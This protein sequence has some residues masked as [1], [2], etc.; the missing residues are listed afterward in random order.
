MA[1]ARENVVIKIDVDAKGIRPQ[2]KLVEERLKAF[3]RSVERNERSLK[4]LSTE[5]D[6][7]QRK[8]GVFNRTLATTNKHV[9]TTNKHVAKSTSSINKASTAM[10]RASSNA[11]KLNRRVGGLG[12]TFRKVGMFAQK[13][14]KVLTKFSFIVYAVEV[15]VLTT[16]LLGA[17][18]A[19]ATGRVAAQGYQA[20]LKGVAA[21]AT[22][23]A[24]AIAVAAASMRQFQEAQLAPFVGGSSAAAR[25]TRGMDPTLVGLMGREEAGKSVASLAKQGV[26]NGQQ[27][28][29]LRQLYNISGGDTSQVSSLIAKLGDPA[30]FSEEVKGAAGGAFASAGSSKFSTSGELVSALGSGSLT[31]DNLQGFAASMGST[32]IGTLKTE[33]STLFGIFA[34]IGESLI[35]PFR[36]TVKL[37]ASTV[38]NFVIDITPAIMQLGEVM[39]GEKGI[40]SGFQKMADRLEGLIER[41]MP[42]M[43]GFMETMGRWSENTEMFFRR[44]GDAMGPLE[45]GAEVIMDMFGS[46]FGGMVG[47]GVLANFNKTLT[48]NADTFRAL[49]DSIGNLFRAFLGGSAG[50]GMLDFV[51]GLTD[52]FNTFATEV[53][54]PLKDISERLWDIILVGLPPILD[55]LGD[56]LQVL[57]GVVTTVASVTGAASSVPGGSAVAAAAT[58]GLFL[59]RSNMRA[60]KAG[61]A[62]QGAAYVRGPGM[63]AQSRSAFNKWGTSALNFGRAPMQGPAIGGGTLAARGA[64]ATMAGGGLAIGGGL[65]ALNSAGDAMKGDNSA[66]NI[67]QGAA[68][69]AAI[70]SMIPVVGTVVG[71]GIGAAIAWGVGNWQKKQNEGNSDKY[72][73]GIFGED[74]ELNAAERLNEYNYAL[75]NQDQIIQQIDG[76]TQ[77]FTDKMADLKGPMADLNDALESQMAPNIKFLQEEL[78]YTAEHARDFALSLDGVVNVMTGM[79]FGAFDDMVQ[80]M[81]GFSMSGSQMFAGTDAAATNRRAGLDGQMDAIT[82]AGGLEEAYLQS[83]AIVEQLF[84]SLRLEG[85]LRGETDAGSVQ[86]AMEVLE[87]NFGKSDFLDQAAGTFIDGWGETNGILTEGFA[88]TTAGL[89]DLLG[90]TKGFYNEMITKGFKEGVFDR[91]LD[92]ALGGTATEAGRAA[93]AAGRDPN[94]NIYNSKT[95]G[96][97][98][99]YGATATVLTRIANDV[100]VESPVKLSVSGVLQPEAI[101]TIVNAVNTQ[102]I[103]M[104]AL[105]GNALSDAATQIDTSDVAPSNNTHDFGNGGSNFDNM[106][107]GRAAGPYG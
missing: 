55:V 6:K 23:A 13:F 32:M 94:S 8:M 11:N 27:N 19:M 107:E 51:R 12:M 29:V 50:D 21:G 104:E 96:V 68:G 105:V 31:A 98:D 92:A 7:F 9:A 69:G 46:I 26:G 17:K 91:T 79:Q 49:G 30:A 35:E 56:L 71:A 63:F 54:P 67:G 44:M 20:A 4:N 42:L 43:G 88:S 100:R 81:T 28:A 61:R 75:E 106:N 47:N 102:L 45:S 22:A 99:S 52:V 2:L 18:L 24:V 87:G 89:T 93:A 15:A 78:G 90:E 64:A 48:E 85:Q 83:P 33:G 40:A 16:A 73:D 38:R 36:Q 74:S 1:K 97:M 82:A 57:S 84:D 5:S 101:Q 70:G 25:L 76:D 72:F 62:A 37:V 66:F 60:A 41:S 34:S 58:G 10:N 80:G 77:R 39:G 65:L 59:G 53:V 3:Q 95:R 14:F 103:D 86:Y